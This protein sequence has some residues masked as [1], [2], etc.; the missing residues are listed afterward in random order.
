MLQ[1]SRLDAWLTAQVFQKMVDLSQL[2]PAWWG[3][4]AATVLLA[5][6]IVL[7][8]NTGYSPLSVICVLCMAIALLATYIEPLYASLEESRW[9]RYVALFDAA[10]TTSALLP[11]QAVEQPDLLAIWLV[12]SVCFTSYLYFPTCRPPRPRQPRQKTVIRHAT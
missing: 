7:A 6:G 5:V 1:L 2:R 4:Q 10:I 12:A 8:V 3:R 11:T 9:A